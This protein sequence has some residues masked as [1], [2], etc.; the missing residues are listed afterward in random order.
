MFR[1]LQYRL[2]I[3]IPEFFMSSE[4]P[5]LFEI[6]QIFPGSEV[7]IPFVIPNLVSYLTLIFISKSPNICEKIC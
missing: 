1:E 4:F 2:T 5:C 7:T 6:N 3:M